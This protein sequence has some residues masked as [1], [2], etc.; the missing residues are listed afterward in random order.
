M[1]CVD[2][3]LSFYNGKKKRPLYRSTSFFFIFFLLSLFFHLWPMSDLIA[4]FFVYGTNW[5]TRAY[6]TAEIYGIFMIDFY[7]FHS[8]EIDLSLLKPEHRT[9]HRFSAIYIH[10]C[11]S[12]NIGTVKAQR[13]ENEMKKKIKMF[14]HNSNCRPINHIY[15][16]SSYFLWKCV[17]FFH[18]LFPLFMNIYWFVCVACSTRCTHSASCEIHDDFV[19]LGFCALWLQ[20][21]K[22]MNRQKKSS[23]VPNCE[24]KT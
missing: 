23:K 7:S 15:M 3:R 22:K 1:C 12:T 14:T 10:H 21:R 2:L 9:N 8:I 20:F 24:K 13:T 4:F 16:F 11:I 5:K 6:F 19:L 18:T 17:C